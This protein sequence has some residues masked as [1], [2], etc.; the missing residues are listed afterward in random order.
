MKNGMSLQ[1]LLT[2]VIEQNENK[3]D[4]VADTKESIRMIDFGG[5]PHIVLL[6]EG[7]RELE[8]FSITENAHR[9]LATRLNIPWKYYQ[10]LLRDH[11][12]LVIIQVN[13]LFEREPET[14]MLRTLDGQARAFLSDRYRR[15]DNKEVLEQV[16]P[17]IVK[18]DIA[19]TML[20][21][22][23]GDNNM[24][25]KV[26]FTD[27]SLA[28]DLGPTANPNR[29]DAWGENG[30]LDLDREHNVIARRDRGRDVVRPG[31]IL[32]NS[33][34]GHGSLNLRGFFFR[35]YCLNGC[36]WG[37]EDAFAMKRTHI[38]GQLIADQDFQIFSDETQRKEDQLIVAQVTEAI[39]TMAD[40]T[41]VQAMGDKLRALKNG[42]QAVDKTGAIQELGRQVDLTEGE[43]KSALENF[44]TDGDFSQWGAVNAVTKIA[45]QD[46]VS[47]ERACELE[48]IGA[49]I[50]DFTNSQWLKVATA[51]AVAA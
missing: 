2:T 3:R 13:A 8:R 19:S 14:R 44:L 27:D 29:A 28:V 16:L 32:S 11:L 48:E 37:K 24:H 50:I 45:N 25:L 35:S 10:R 15:L 23:V 17:P 1:D 9:Q 21:S 46:D 5:K 7:A 51:E 42:E 22:N 20:S 49:K 33:E 26:L 41:R 6:Q 4:F 38:G 31:F 30:N 47:Y 34:T 12:D 39:G 43:T 40:A 18:G 36:V